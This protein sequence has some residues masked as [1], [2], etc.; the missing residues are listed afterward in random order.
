MSPGLQEG[1][2]NLSLEPLAIPLSQ[3]VSK[4]MKGHIKKDSKNK[5]EGTSPGLA[6]WNSLRT[7]MIM[8]INELLTIENNKKFMS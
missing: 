7:K 2:H 3:K 6:N 5:L 4:K 1:R 8:N